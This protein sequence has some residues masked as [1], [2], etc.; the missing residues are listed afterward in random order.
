M[1]VDVDLLLEKPVLLNTVLKHDNSHG[2]FAEA[3]YRFFE[4]SGKMES[5][6]TSLVRDQAGMQLQAM[7]HEI[8]PLREE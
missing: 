3:V 5:L 4:V 7:N 6:V 1:P 8:L 2:S